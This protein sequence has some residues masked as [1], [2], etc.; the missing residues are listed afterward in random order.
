MPSKNFKGKSAATQF[1]S[2]QEAVKNGQKG[3]IASGQAKRKQKSLRELAQTLADTPIKDPKLISQMAKAGVSDDDMNWNM[4]VAVGLRNKAATG[5]SKAVEKWEEWVSRDSAA[6]DGTE[7]PLAIMRAHFWENISSNFGQLSVCAIKHR[8][9]HY[10][11]FGGRGSTKS[12]W[13]S[14]MGIRLIMEHEDIHGLVLRKVGNTLRDS[15]YSQY[16]WAIGVLGVSEYWDAK[17]NPLDFALWK[18]AKA[19][20]P[21]WDS[22]WGKGRPN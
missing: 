11:V 21:F 8:Y 10:D 3:G 18:S 6:E 14:L 12:S 17:K 19:G 5:D 1:K 2:G 4:A 16:I 22:P 20:E 7:K 13:A 15:V 9:T